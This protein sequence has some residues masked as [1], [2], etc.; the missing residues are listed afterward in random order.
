MQTSNQNNFYCVNL[1]D[2]L[3]LKNGEEFVNDKISNFFFTKY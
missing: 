1:L 2:F 3:V